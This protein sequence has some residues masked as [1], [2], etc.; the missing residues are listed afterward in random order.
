MPAF[1]GAVGWGADTPH[2]RK[3]YVVKNLNRS[4]PGSLLDGIPVKERRIMVFRVSGVIELNIKAGM[5]TAEHSSFTI[6]G[7]TSPGGITLTNGSGSSW[8][9]YGVDL[10]DSYSDTSVSGPG[11]RLPS[12]TGSSISGTS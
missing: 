9:S 5:L 7:Q 6:A 8:V 4:G 1:P 10:H 2:G 3:V 12:I 11:M